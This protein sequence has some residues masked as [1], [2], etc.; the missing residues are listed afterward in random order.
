[1]WDTRFYAKDRQYYS[2]YWNGISSDASF[3]GRYREL[4]TID[5]VLV[6]G[7]EPVTQYYT[8]TMTIGRG[9]YYPFYSFDP[10]GDADNPA[11]SP[12]MRLV[13]VMEIVSND[14][15]RYSVYVDGEVAS[16]T[17]SDGTTRYLRGIPMDKNRIFNWIVDTPIYFDA[18]AG[19]DDLDSGDGDDWPHPIAAIAAWDRALTE[20][21]IALL[22]GV[23]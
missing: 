5:E 1:M 13:L 2:F 8:N 16:Y 9:S 11:L 19:S 10:S 4:Y 15:S 14:E 3:F 18:D 22:G 20:D 21:E 7:E 12:W 23:K 17:V 6:D